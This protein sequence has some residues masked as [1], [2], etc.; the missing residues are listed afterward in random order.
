MKHD[1]SILV[2]LATLMGAL[3]FTS[4]AKADTP[5]KV[6]NTE[7][8]EKPTAEAP[9]REMRPLSTDRP[10]VTESPISVDRGHFQAEIEV[11]RYTVDEGVTSYSF[12]NSNLKFGLTNFWDIQLVVESVVGLEEPTGYNFG[13]GDLTL[14]NKFNIFGNDGGKIALGVMPW[15]KAPTAGTRGNKYFEGGGIVLLGVELPAGFASGFMVEADAMRNALGDGYHLEV[16]TTAT[17]GH[18]IVGP[19]GAYFEVFGTYSADPTADYALSVDGGLTY[20]ITPLFQLDVGVV[21]GLT[22]AAEDFSVFSG[23][24]F[25]I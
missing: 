11:A 21:G 13:F 17:I 4:S 7:D 1:K 18:S 12:A 22:E 24:S 14:R 10:D 23:L 9:E 25:K 16:L 3:A 2:C 6:E 8:G 5:K 19:L 20:L 15:I